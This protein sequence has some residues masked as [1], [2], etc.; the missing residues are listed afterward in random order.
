MV[1]EL[2]FLARAGQR[3]EFEVTDRVQSLKSGDVLSI[4]ELDV[5]EV[6][7]TLTM[8]IIPL[9]LA[10]LSGIGGFQRVEP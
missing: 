6:A 2:P 5:D 4:T 1:T 9:Q 10:T 8:H 3:L 7:M